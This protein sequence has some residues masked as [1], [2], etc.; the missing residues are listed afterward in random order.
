[1]AARLKL[2]K[3][4]QCLSAEL[5]RGEAQKM[6]ITI[7]S[8]FDEPVEVERIDSTA[9]GICISL[10]PRKVP[11]VPVHILQKLDRVRRLHEEAGKVIEEVSETLKS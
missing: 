5:C 7:V 1:M 3:S 6:N 2:S 11:A 10:K 8:A 4:T 9:D